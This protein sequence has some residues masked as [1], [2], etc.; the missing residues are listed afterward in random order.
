MVGG[1]IGIFLG[2][3]TLAKTFGDRIR[4]IAIPTIHII[5][6]RGPRKVFVTTGTM[7]RVFRLRG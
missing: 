7:F 6:S 3:S 4:P 5:V 2:K 1:I